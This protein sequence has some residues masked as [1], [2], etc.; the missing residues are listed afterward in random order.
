MDEGHETAAAS[1]TC[2]QRRYTDALICCVEST[3]LLERGPRGQQPP[4]RVPP[5]SIPME[6]VT[7]IGAAPAE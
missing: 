3:F 5:T 7:A 6:S 1:G 4:P 2:A